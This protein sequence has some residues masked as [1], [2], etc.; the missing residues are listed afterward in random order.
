MGFSLLTFA[1]DIGVVVMHGKGGNPDKFVNTL[2]D[3]LRGAGFDVANL[4]MPWSG[5]R[6]Y[7]TTMQGAVDEINAA[8]DAMRAKGAKKV[9]VA[10]HS[11]GGLF[12][13]YYGGV[14]QADGIVTIAPG[15]SH[16]SKVFRDALG[17][18]VA[19]AKSMMD[20]GRGNETSQ[21]SDYEGS[22]GRF[23]VTTRASVYYDWF[24]PD[25]PHNMDI[26]T[27]KLKSGTPVLYVAPTR[28]YPALKSIK[29]ASFAALPVHTMTR[30]IEPDADHLRAPS[31]AAGDII[32]WLREAAAQ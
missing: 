21:F 27:R 4:E 15:G 8:A 24:N 7:D 23:P 28:D 2:A 22:K 30:M 19:E 9:Y 3:E 12:A 18:L 14:T 1:A 25:G 26:V 11:Q 17:G 13:L 6:Q 31:A 32:S 10:G 20:A 5:R 29:S 16:G